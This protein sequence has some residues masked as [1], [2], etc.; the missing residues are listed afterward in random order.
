MPTLNPGAQYTQG[1]PENQR[2]RIQTSHNQSGRIWFVPTNPEAPPPSNSSRSFGPLAIDQTFG[3]F[4]VA[5]DIF[6]VNDAGS[7]GAL[8][9]TFFQS[10]GQVDNFTVGGA[11]SVFGSYS[12]SNGT[13]SCSGTGAKTL[14]ATTANVTL[15]ATTTGLTT[16]TRLDTFTVVS[17]DS[18]GTPGNATNNN[19]SGRAAFAAAGSTVVI[20]NSKVTA[21]SKVFVS[22]A[23]GDA[24]LTSVRVTPAAGSFTVTGNVAATATTVFDF[25]VVN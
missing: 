2:I 9:Y 13:F 15:G 17:T 18:S 16:L 8:T 7:A 14:T 4:G 6:I 5:G 22:L 10:N 11:L 1:L 24:T 12:Q 20:T 25:F 19:L 3:P 23:G 21:A